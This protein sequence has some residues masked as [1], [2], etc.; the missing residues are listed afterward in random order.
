MSTAF[1]D[2]LAR[3]AADATSRRVR[4]TDDPI[5]T[6]LD[7]CAAEIRE[8]VLGLSVTPLSP[9]EFASREGVS[10]Q[11]VTTWCRLGQVE[12]YRDT[13]NHWRIPPHAKRS[14]DRAA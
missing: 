12:A 8:V 9:A 2:L 6:T 7:L 3:W 11:A 4:C 1:D 13:N 14:L 5:A 10:E